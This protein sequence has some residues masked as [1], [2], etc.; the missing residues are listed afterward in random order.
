MM[1]L[2]QSEVSMSVVSTAAESSFHTV[3]RINT[4]SLRYHDI[5][6]SS[7]R[8]KHVPQ[9][10]IGDILAFSIKICKEKNKNNKQDRKAHTENLCILY[11]TQKRK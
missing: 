11:T 5:K 6:T 4:V 8:L 1:C 2:S 10:L 3:L 9:N 7:V